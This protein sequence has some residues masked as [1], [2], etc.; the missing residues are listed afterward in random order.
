[1]L[2]LQHGLSA[3]M[4]QLLLLR[5]MMRVM[6]RVLVSRRGRDGGSRSV[7][8]LLM[9]VLLLLMMMRRRRWRWVLVQEVCRGEEVRRRRDWR[10]RW[11]QRRRRLVQGAKFLAGLV[12]HVSG[13]RWR[14]VS[15]CR[16]G[17]CSSGSRLGSCFQHLL[18]SVLSTL[19]QLLEAVLAHRDTL[20]DVANR[21]VL[22]QSSEHHD[23][24]G[25]QEDVD[26]LDVGDLGKLRVGAGHEGRHGQ[27]SQDSQLD[28]SW[29]GVA[30]QPK[31]NPADHDDQGGGDVDLDQVVAH[32]AD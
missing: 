10:R 22:Q 29:R 26:R 19:L 9:M 1:M 2:V 15:G 8:G 11:R 27:D 25:A 32:G 3:V 5:V 17:G 23:E 4:R 7:R 24:T 20:A 16:G 30:V 14:G 6:M 28:A 13:L 21:R 12:P 18:P 31:G